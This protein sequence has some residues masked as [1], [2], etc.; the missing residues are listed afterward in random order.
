MS[1]GSMGKEFTLSS[2]ISSEGNAFNALTKLHLLQ[3][4]LKKQKVSHL[5][6]TAFGCYNVQRG[7]VIL[8]LLNPRWTYRFGLIVFRRFDQ[9]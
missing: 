1:K 4:F 8:V 5:V 3:V 9:L 7:M 6:T 2:D